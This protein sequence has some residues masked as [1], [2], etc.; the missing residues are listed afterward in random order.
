MAEQ[1]G[2][3]M[4]KF[5]RSVTAFLI[6]S[7]A[8]A[9]GA[10]A[11]GEA[12]RFDYY[13]LALSWSP[14]YCETAGRND[15]VQCDG[16][17]AYAFVLH[18]LWP[19]YQRG[20]PQDCRIAERPWVPQPL[21]DKMLDIMPS[22][23]LVIH[24]YKKHGTCSGLSPD[25][26]FDLARKLYEKIKIPARFQ[27]P[28]EPLVLTPK[29]IEDEFLKANPELKS[30]M[31]VVACRDRRLTELRFCFGRDEKLKSCGDNENPS[32]LCSTDKVIMPPVRAR[33]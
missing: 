27:A 23:K 26:Y 21:I 22:P 32:K 28:K 4:G 17:R 30:N 13:A 7:A 2:Q 18:G 19:Q 10:K 11:G 12:G 25:G 6:V 33:R 14:A 1:L 3:H 5:I 24:E 29:E 20:W 9:T 15:R 16:S 31:F 8:V